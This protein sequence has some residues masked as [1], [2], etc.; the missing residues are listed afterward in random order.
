MAN[1][2]IPGGAGYVGGWLVDRALEAGHEVRV[3]DLLLYEDRYLKD[4]DFVGG[5]VLDTERLR[6]H[7]DWADT[8][9]W[10]AALVGDPACALD[11]T[12][13]RKINVESVDWLC[14]SFDG[15]IVF[16]STCSVYGAQDE[17]LDEQSPTAPLSLYAETK[18]EAERVLTERRPEQPHLP[19]GDARRAR[20]HLLAH[21]PRP[22]RQPAGSARQDDRRALRSS[23][24][25]ST[26]RC[27]T[28]ATSPPRSSP[29]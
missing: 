4:V 17:V 22:G 26:G 2:L 15:R 1:V 6:P 29:T 11:P 12:L 9:V 13:T 19:A 14:A 28:C 10:L 24:A 8:V 23:A 20:R 3:Y 16:P 27:C 5:D 18:L 21:P 25:S 7:L